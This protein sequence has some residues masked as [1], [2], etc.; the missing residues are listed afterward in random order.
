MFLS[1]ANQEPV[2]QET[3]KLLSILQIYAHI[4]CASKLYLVLLAD[5][6][7]SYFRI[8]DKALPP[9]PAINYPS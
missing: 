8:R 2:W 1:R 7:F 9:R 3:T 4:T 5:N 6:I